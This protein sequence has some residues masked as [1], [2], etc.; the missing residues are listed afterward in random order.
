VFDKLGEIDDAG[1][2]GNSSVDEK[3]EANYF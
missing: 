2:K 3:F 1:Y